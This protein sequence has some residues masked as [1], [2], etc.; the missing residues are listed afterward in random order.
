MSQF[1]YL[2]CNVIYDWYA[3]VKNKIQKFHA[4]FS[5]IMTTLQLK[6]RQE[7]NLKLYK[8]IVIPVLVYGSE[9]WTTSLLEITKL[10]AEKIR[11]L[12][13]G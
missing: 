7:T 10:Q 8:M 1:T 13:K 9:F 6:S 4:I 5:K 2:G 3:Y 11:F 12:E